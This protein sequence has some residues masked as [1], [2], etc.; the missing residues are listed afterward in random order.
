MEA[1]KS[2]IRFE[3]ETMAALMGAI[4]KTC[5]RKCLYKMD[6]PEL[7]VAELACT[8]RCVLKF[9]QAQNQVSHT[10]LVHR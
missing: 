2:Q 5:A 6:D 3:M 10:W 9:L 1:Q 7:E 4:S 8:D